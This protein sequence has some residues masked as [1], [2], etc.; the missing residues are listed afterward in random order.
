MRGHCVGGKPYL[1]GLG[2][3]EQQGRDLAR[4][5]RGHSR[6][7][8]EATDP[9]EDVVPRRSQVGRGGPLGGMVRGSG[10]IV[11]LYGRI[12]RTSAHVHVTFGDIVEFEVPGMVV[13]A[14]RETGQFD[15]ATGRTLGL[16][17]RT[18]RVF[19]YDSDRW[20]QVHQHGSIDDPG[21]LRDYQEAVAAST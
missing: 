7:V 15:D 5:R 21:V 3:I 12:F 6:G 8:V 4:L 16:R 17:I 13:F 10:E 18:T 1:G 2:D 14:R 20:G 19:A 9:G 11:G